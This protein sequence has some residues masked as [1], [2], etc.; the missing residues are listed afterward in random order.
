M[1][2]RTYYYRKS[3]AQLGYSNLIELSFS[4]FLFK[5]YKRQFSD[6]NLMFDGEYKRELNF[7]IQQVR[8]PFLS[9][10]HIPILSSLRDSTKSVD[11]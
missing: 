9:N 11:F 2:V 4:E 3:R 10:S 8:N 6:S 5:S 1:Y 7:C